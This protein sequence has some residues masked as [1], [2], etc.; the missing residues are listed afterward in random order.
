MHVG[1]FASVLVATG[2][3]VG[4]GTTMKTYFRCAD[5][6]NAAKTGLILAAFICTAVQVAVLVTARWHGP[7]WLWLGA[8][9]FGLA[10]G[11]FWWALS[12]HGKS[13]P[14]FAFI[15]VPPTT[16]TTAGPYRFVRHPIYSAYLLA[17]CAGAVTAAQ[18]WLLAG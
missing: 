14:A 2:T 4:F 3:W 5:Q 9:G 7:V 6:R 8:C 13:H 12:A 15:R 17:W 1:Q 10:N 11:L 16:L 18:P